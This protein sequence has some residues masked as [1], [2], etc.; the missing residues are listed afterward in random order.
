MFNNSNYRSH[1]VL[2][3]DNHGFVLLANGHQSKE[4]SIA[5][6]KGQAIVLNKISELLN[7]LPATL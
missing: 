2:I 6:L 3:G 7:I 4:R 5:A 1:V